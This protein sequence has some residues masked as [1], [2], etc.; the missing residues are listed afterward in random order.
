MVM[1]LCMSKHVNGYF[2]MDSI[3]EIYWE[4]WMYSVVTDL[5]NQMHTQ[6]YEFV[7]DATGYQ[8]G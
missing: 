6:Y 1:L 3:D 7:K 5:Y 4:T 2:D 8:V